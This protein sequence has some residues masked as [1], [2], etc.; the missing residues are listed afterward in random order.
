MIQTED[1]KQIFK[2]IQTKRGYKPPLEWR[3]IYAPEDI[4]EDELI[5]D[6][7]LNL[8]RKPVKWLPNNLKVH[9]DLYLS[10]SDIKSLP[11]GLVVGRS[12][13]LAGTTIENLPDDLKVGEN[14]FLNFTQISSL[15]N[16]LSIGGFIMVDK[17][18]ID[19]FREMYPQYV[20]A[21]WRR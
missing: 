18:K 21:G 16:N 19:Q 2:L 11:K 12:L 9:D 1:L 13:F 7:S 14:L 20:I 5:V 8:D 15:P 6:G 10:N 17:T 3:F 4:D